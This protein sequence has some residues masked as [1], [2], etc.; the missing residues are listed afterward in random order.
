MAA[1]P[2]VRAQCLTLAHPFSLIIRA[3]FRRPGKFITDAER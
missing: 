3:S 1:I 2:N